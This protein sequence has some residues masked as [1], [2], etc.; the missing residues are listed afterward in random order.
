MANKSRK[1]KFSVENFNK[2]MRKAGFISIR[3]M[4]N[5]YYKDTIV[6]RY[7]DPDKSNIVKE[8]ISR[9]TLNRALSD[10]EMSTRSLKLFAILFSCTEEFLMGEP[11]ME[12]GPLKRPEWIPEDAVKYCE[13]DVIATKEIMNEVTKN[14]E[15]ETIFVFTTTQQDPI[16]VKGSRLYWVSEKND[17]DTDVYSFWSYK[18]GECDDEWKVAEIKSACIVGIVRV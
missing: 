4:C 7:Y 13:N 9:K 12:E 15:E 5:E 8:T 2:A 14:N 1:I 3:D 17:N 16:M 11:E 6:I 10:G 18:K